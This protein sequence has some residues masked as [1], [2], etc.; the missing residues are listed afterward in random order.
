MIRL[1]QLISRRMSAHMAPTDSVRGKTFPVDAGEGGSRGSK[2]QGR[3][4]SFLLN[5]ED[6]FP[7]AFPKHWWQVEKAS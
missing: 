2:L 6:I 1:L 4:V 7:N 3:Q 5:L